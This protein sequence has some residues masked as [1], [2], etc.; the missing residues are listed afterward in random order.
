MPR[1]VLLLIVMIA[2]A[3]ST[4]VT[5]QDS[6][7]VVKYGDVLDVIAAGFDVSVACIAENSGL[8]NPNQL[9]PG[10]TL[11]IDR[12]CPPYD[13]L[14]P[15]ARDTTADQGGGSAA[16]SRA[17]DYT[18]VR[19]D[20][21]DLIAATFDVSVS[22]LAEA[23]DLTDPNRIYIGDTL[24]IDTSCPPYDGLALGPRP[25]VRDEAAGQGGGGSG[26]YVVQRGDVLDLIAARFNVQEDCLAEAN[27]L[28]NK[29]RIF[30]GDRLEIDTSCPEY[31]GE[32]LNT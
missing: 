18:V 3:F 1:I 9:R 4:T 31:D 15:I 30:P 19:G 6:T 10:D 5:A 23:N 29:H 2:L 11:I 17:G 7:Y 8:L 13:G 14:I 26:D 20:V 21:L 27:G 16:Q 24:E 22:C 28:A 32:A 12:S 25:Q